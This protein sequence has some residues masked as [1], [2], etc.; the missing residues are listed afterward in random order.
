MV[1][2]NSG[3]LF[4]VKRMTKMDPLSKRILEA[5]ELT[6][7][8]E[9]LKPVFKAADNFLGSNLGGA[10]LQASKTA[11]GKR[12]PIQPERIRTPEEQAAIDDIKM[13]EARFWEAG[14]KPNKVEGDPLW[15]A[16]QEWDE[17]NKKKNLIKKNLLGGK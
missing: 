1:D 8:G 11:T 16:Y 12:R 6:K 7:T 17:T 2:K 13:S 9:R 4:G 10:I 15:E 3:E 14:F 5:E